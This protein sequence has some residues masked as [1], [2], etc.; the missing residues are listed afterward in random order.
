MRACI[1]IAMSQQ[2]NRTVLVVLLVLLTGV[3]SVLLE[4]LHAH[5]IIGSSEAAQQIMGSIRDQARIEYAKTG[6]PPKRL[7]DFCNPADLDSP[8]TDRGAF[9]YRGT[10]DRCFI[11]FRHTEPYHGV[12][13]WMEALWVGGSGQLYHDDYPIHATGFDFETDP[14]LARIQQA[15]R[16]YW[17]K[18]RAEW[19]TWKAH[20]PIWASFALLVFL[21]ICNGHSP[22]RLRWAGLALYLVLGGFLTAAIL[23]GPVPS[24]D[25]TG[26][27]HFTSF[28]PFL[29]TVMLPKSNLGWL[30]R[31]C[32][33]PAYVLFWST[34]GAGS[35]LPG[36]VFLYNSLRLGAM[37]LMPWLCLVSWKPN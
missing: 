2:H 1:V 22:G 37:C 33:V 14:A 16:V 20:S 6:K 23:L 11:Y 17:A 9:G 5:S 10:A 13:M 25:Y 3:G 27:M 21:L 34:V 31:F 35:E 15:N 29:A 18:S 26:T 4:P 7:S 30:G 32:L 12:S 8:W 28:I 36:Q 19:N 24:R